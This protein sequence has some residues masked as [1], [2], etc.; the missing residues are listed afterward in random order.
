MT[1]WIPYLC[2]GRGLNDRLHWAVRAKHTKRERGQVI[3]AFM[4]YEL[5]GG[6]LPAQPY[7]VRLVRVYSARERLMDDD[8][9]VGACKGAR[10]Q[11][12]AQLGVNDGD[13]EAIR[14]QYEQ[15]RGTKSGVRIEIAQRYISTITPH[16]ST[17]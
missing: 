10:D 2:L 13:R 16:S 17:G 1:I 14:F 8:N 11:I 4:Q 12:A 3:W 9:W 7:D 15:E 6:K 5:G